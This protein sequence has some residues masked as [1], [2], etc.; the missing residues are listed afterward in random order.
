MGLIGRS[1][2]WRKEEWPDRAEKYRR[3]PRVKGENKL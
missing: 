3:K 2:V 1:R